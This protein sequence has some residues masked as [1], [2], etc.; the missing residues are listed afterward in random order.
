MHNERTK[1]VIDCKMY[2][3]SNKVVDTVQC[4]VGTID[5]LH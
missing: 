2:D 3:C 1:V 5:V 4:F